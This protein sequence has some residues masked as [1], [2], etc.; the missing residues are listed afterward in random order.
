MGSL[1]PLTAGQSLGWNGQDIP[2]V[3]ESILIVG[4]GRPFSLVQNAVNACSERGVIYVMP[5]E[6]DED[7]TVDKPLTIRGIGPRHSVRITGVAAGTST[8]MT[9]D[10][11]SD[12]GLY[13]LNMEARSGGDGLLMIGS[14]R[15]VEVLG[16][17][18]GGGTNA[19]RTSSTGTGTQVFDWRV[20]DTLIHNATNGINIAYAGGADPNGQIL[21]KGCRFSKIATDCIVQDGFTNDWEIVDNVFSAVSGTE[22]TRFLDIDDTSTTGLVANNV[23]HTTVHA[24]G[25]LKL[26]AGVL[27]VNNRTQAENPGTDAYAGSG[28]PD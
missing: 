12:V 3:G 20:E 10:A 4:A 22:P 13:N 7:V 27:Y 19:I 18:V 17:K 2:P 21:V 15:R 24:T 25:K 6:Y 28:R 23:F 14:I 26:A 9:I 8:P 5:G 1:Y 11:A 16:C